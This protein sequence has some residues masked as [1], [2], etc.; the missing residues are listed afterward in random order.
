MRK[1]GKKRIGFDEGKVIINEYA[2]Y[3][4]LLIK[5]CLLSD[6]IKIQLNFADDWWVRWVSTYK[7]WD[8][9]KW[10]GFKRGFWVELQWIRARTLR[11]RW[12][13]LWGGK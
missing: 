8:W 10:G 11:V 5:V 3:W 13:S 4:Y 1:K 7:Q 2:K 6:S 12:G 9:V